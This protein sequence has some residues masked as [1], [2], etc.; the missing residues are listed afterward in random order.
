[1]HWAIE[2]IHVSEANLTIHWP[3][4]TLV[5]GCMNMDK[6]AIKED[7]SHPLAANWLGV[8]HY[9]GID[10]LNEYH[11]SICSD[12]YPAYSDHIVELCTGS[13]KVLRTWDIVKDCSSTQE[14]KTQVIYVESAFPTLIQRDTI[15][16]INSGISCAVDVVLRPDL[17]QYCGQV[18]QVTAKI[19]HESE[20]E[21]CIPYEEK[22]KVDPI[23]YTDGQ[24]I[25]PDVEAGCNYIEMYVQSDCFQTDTLQFNITVEDYLAPVV[26]CDQAATVVLGSD[27]IG[28]LAPDNVDNGSWDNCGIS[29]MVLIKHDSTCPIDSL[30]EPLEDKISFCCAEIGAPIK[31]ALKVTDL[32]GNESSCFINVLISENEYPTV[33]CPDN[34]II[35][36]TTDFHD[37]SI[38]G[39]PWAASVCSDYEFIYQDSAKQNQCRNQLIKREWYLVRSQDTNLVCRHDIQLFNEHPFTEKQII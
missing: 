29:S 5:Y 2:D 26:V 3:K 9:A 10:S 33:E 36:C 24:I 19:Y 11:H 32:S 22:L 8:P 28:Y 6:E 7:G 35:P 38:T 25:I 17:S 15:V 27:G 20:M 31:V 39:K 16:R 13:Y 18:D 30:A 12:L 37:L 4:D 23:Q 14:Q 21:Y 34:L 1:M